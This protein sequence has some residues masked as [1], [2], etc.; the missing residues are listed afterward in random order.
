ME[1]KRASSRGDIHEMM[2]GQLETE[3]R[4]RI[5]IKSIAAVPAD[6]REKIDRDRQKIE[7]LF[8]NWHLIISKSFRRDLNSLQ[9]HYLSRG[10]N[11]VNAN[12][13][14][15]ALNAEHFVDV[16]MEEVKYLVKNCTTF[17]PATSHLYVDLG[18]K[19]M[20]RYQIEMKVRNGIVDKTTQIYEKY[21]NILLNSNT[22]DNARQIWQRLE[23]DALKSGPSLNV[24]DQLWP[25]AVL[26]AIGK[27]LYNILL[28]DLKID[29]SIN[30]IGSMQRSKP[31]MVPVFYTLLR[32]RDKTL[33]EEIK[34]HPA[35]IKLY[36]HYEF[37]LLNI[38][39]NLI[40]M[41]SPPLPWTSPK[42]GAYLVMHSDLIRLPYVTQL[43]LERIRNSPK[44][45][46]YP[47]LD[48]L[49]QLAR[50]PWKINTRILDVLIKVFN[51][52]GS[53]KLNVAQPASI[54]DE[55][56][57]KLYEK[58]ESAKYQEIQK[59]KQRKSE[60]YSIWCDALYRL[61]LAN[62]YRDKKFWLPQN[63]DFRGR[64]YPLPPH[65]NHI[66]SDYS[67]CLFLFHEGRPLGK[68][69]YRW[70][71]LHCINL[72]GH[73]K[74]SPIAERLAYAE[75][76]L[77]DIIDSADNPLTGRM[78]WAE[79]EDPWQT[80]ACCMEI[81]DVSRCPDPAKHICHLPIHQ[82]G[83]CNGLQHYAALGR[84]Q[85]GAMSV[86]LSNM[87]K[88]QDVYAE[89]AAKVEKIRKFDALS[90]DET[91][92]ILKGF[93]TRKVV[94]QVVM[95]TVYGVTRFG[96]R[97]QIER[98]LK[99]LDN[100]PPDFVQQ[101]SIYLTKNTFV[102]LRAMFTSAKEIQ[103]WFTQCARLIS[104]IRLQHVEWITPLGLPVFQPYSKPPSNSA[105]ASKYTEKSKARLK[106]MP[107]MA[108]QKNAFPP[109]FI[110]SLDSTHMM[111]TSLNCEKAGILFVSVHDCF[112]THPSSVTEMNKICR[113]Q[114]VLLHSQPILEDLSNFFVKKYGF[115]SK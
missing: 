80:L 59:L 38:D 67:R 14:L 46:L 96:A 91:A 114:F 104:G 77:D 98:Q 63:M 36:Q 54:V 107:N 18:R 94:K 81:A 35:F 7:D 39:A 101:A 47:V 92:I 74:K 75:E 32:H 66:G 76:V 64:V 12:P 1:H 31:Y 110:H 15:R 88:P 48:S 11:S 43:Q 51:S 27:F 20:L 41:M 42:I 70:L 106:D 85:I 60:L 111:L 49:N 30:Q 84:D 21:C 22:T 53:E 19:V 44:C 78:W 62:H 73:K 52:G 95:T 45:N 103:D 90:G 82:D 108:K 83:S 29:V 68:D 79:S 100:F 16:L 61:S 65:L 113:N 58:S 13:Y 87:P 34:V 93:I 9:H 10:F 109:N 97:L 3:L 102:S 4:G 50:V 8:K 71:K 2:Q 37:G 72:I 86:N 112:W 25:N 57:A 6:V 115:D 26:L 5:T 56:L 23:H 105:I 33:K 24:D 28:R 40:P 17:T 89:V 99:N 69:G 55:E